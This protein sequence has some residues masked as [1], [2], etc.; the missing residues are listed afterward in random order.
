MESNNKETKEN[1]KPESDSKQVN[2]HRKPLWFL[3]EIFEWNF[4][5]V[6]YLW[7][8]G[9]I[10]RIKWVR[11]IPSSSKSVELE[12]I[13]GNRTMLPCHPLDGL[14][15]LWEEDKRG[16][17]LCCYDNPCCFMDMWLGQFWS[18]AMGGGDEA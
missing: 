13:Y 11:L 17:A 4:W 2:H 10:K 18:L 3:R 12:T 15:W 6:I 9:G 5:E 14:C 1:Q 7:I 8:G 16:P